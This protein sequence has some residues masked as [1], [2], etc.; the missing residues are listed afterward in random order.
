MR[1]KPLRLSE[2]MIAAITSVADTKGV[3]PESVLKRAIFTYT[4]KYHRANVPVDTT[5]VVSMQRHKELE[6]GE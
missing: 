6:S 1:D 3:S 4:G 5:N 2:D